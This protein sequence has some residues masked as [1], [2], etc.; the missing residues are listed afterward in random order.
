MHGKDNGPTPTFSKASSYP[1][2]YEHGLGDLLGNRPRFF[3]L[4]KNPQPACSHNFEVVVLPLSLPEKR[5]EDDLYRG[6]SIH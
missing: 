5:D 4:N 2:R 1:C 6:K 3:A